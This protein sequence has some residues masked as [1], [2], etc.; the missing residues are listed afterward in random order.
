VARENLSSALRGTALKVR[1]SHRY[2]APAATASRGPNTARDSSDSRGLELVAEGNPWDALD[3]RKVHH[4]LVE[5][6]Q[7][8]L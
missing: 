8:W 2:V 3:V 1:I 6:D 4:R 7:N 5:L